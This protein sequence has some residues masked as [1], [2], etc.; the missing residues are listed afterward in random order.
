MSVLR[1]KIV[2]YYLSCQLPSTEAVQRHLEDFTSTRTA[3]QKVLKKDQDYKQKQIACRVK[4]Q[5]L[6]NLKAERAEPQLSE[7]IGVERL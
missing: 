7:M 6:E 2:E 1:Q 5:R 3:M 4:R